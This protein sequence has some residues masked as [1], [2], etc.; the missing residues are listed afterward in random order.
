MIGQQKRLLLLLCLTICLLLQVQSLLLLRLH[1]A[2]SLRHL[3]PLQLLFKATGLLLDS[4]RLT[5]LLKR[6]FGTVAFSHLNLIIIPTESWALSTC[7]RMSDYALE[8]MGAL[9][10]PTDVKQ[11]LEL[12]FDAI[13]SGS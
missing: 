1:L 8:I 13:M 6:P 4:K 9:H 5:K 7:L 2:R 10:T 12:S 11:Q 3:V